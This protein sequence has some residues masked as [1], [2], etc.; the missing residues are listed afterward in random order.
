MKHRRPCKVNS[1]L[2]SSLLALSG[3]LSALFLPLPSALAQSVDYSV[4]SVAE[5]AGADFMKMTRPSDY[6]CMPVVQRGSRLTWLSNRILAIPPS[7]DLIAYL[8]WRNGATNIFVK[9]LAKQGSSTQ[10][11]NRNSVLDF[12]YSPDG[13]TICFS[14]QRGETNQIFQT[15]ANTGYV[16]RQITS[17]SQDYSPV[18]SSDKK[19]ILFAR[20][21]TYGSSIWSYDV[22]NKFLSTI[23]SGMNPC[24]IPSQS[25]VVCS[26]P[27][28][29]GR[30]ELWKIDTRTGSEE[31]LLSD[32]KH[33][34]TSPQVSPNGRWV[35][36]V[37]DSRLDNGASGYLNTDLFACRIDGTGF[38]QLTYHAAD[39][40]SPIW[41]A[42]GRHIYFVSQRGDAEGKANIWRMN[43]MY[44]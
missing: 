44:E 12:S 4:V 29:E 43:F 32:A 18:Y 7:G 2:R 17:G 6:V 20:A 36:F 16:C 19:Q 27:G 9:D 1:T 41:G 42:D 8:S 5:E 34:F 11:T 21:E 24:P 15:D 31:C 22:A 26:R 35:V 3:A 14:E 37:G 40:L 13:K 30:Y 28:A 25:A 39:D 38:A 10:R 23:S 33:S